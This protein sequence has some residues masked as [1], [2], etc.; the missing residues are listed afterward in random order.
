MDF[1]KIVSDLKN[2]VYHPVY[3][4]MGEEPYFI[5]VIADLIEKNILDASEKE[6][7]QTILYGGETNI[8]Q[9]IGEAKAYPMMSNYRVVIV[10]EAQNMKDMAPRASAKEEGED[11]KHPLEIYLEN[12]QKTTILVFCHKYKTIDMRT[13]FA[14]NIS[15]RAVVMKSDT[16]Y[17]YKVPKWVEGFVKEKGYSIEAHASQLLTEFLGND[18]S[19]I[20]NE[21]GKLFLNVPSGTKITSDHIQKFIGVSKEYNNFELHEAIGRRDVLKANRIINYFAS[22]PK[23]NPL[24]VT[25]ASLAG[26]FSKMLVYHSLADKSQN[27]VA[28]ALKVPPFFVKDYTTAAHNYSF[29]KVTGVVSL[30]REYDMKSKG[31][32]STGVGEG[33]LL[34]ELLFKILH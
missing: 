14:K 32:E 7:N 2:K 12:P 4:L 33:E 25:V 27:N 5:D 28:S 20:A 18:L 13:A 9:V 15:K 6:F 29:A 17:D 22:N 26:Y 16:M 10:R 31:Y 8:R 34:K 11:K 23:D 1:E 19:K 21:L 3:L 30:L 24:V